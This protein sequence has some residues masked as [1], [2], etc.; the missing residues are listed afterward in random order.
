MLATEKLFEY[1][2]TLVYTACCRQALPLRTR[3]RFL[4]SVAGHLAS[5]R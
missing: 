2:Q 5:S 3:E 1:P 4:F